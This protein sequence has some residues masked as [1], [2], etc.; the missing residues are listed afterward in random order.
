MEERRLPGRAEP[1]TCVVLD[2]VQSQANRMEMAL[3]DAFDAGAL[4]L[5]ILQVY[6]QLKAVHACVDDVPP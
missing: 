3:Q 1:V 4:K 2:T 5:P 6:Q